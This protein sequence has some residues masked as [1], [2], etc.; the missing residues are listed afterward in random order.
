M[1]DSE[2]GAVTHPGNARQ[3]PPVL[4]IGLVLDALS[5]LFA[6]ALASRI[7]FALGTTVLA[8]TTVGLFQLAR[9]SGG[10]A[11]LAASA[12]GVAT[13]ALAALQLAAA[14]GLLVVTLWLPF[15]ISAAAAAVLVAI[16]ATRV[17]WMS[18][19]VASAVLYIVALF[20]PALA[21]IDRPLL[22]GEP[23]DNLVFGLTCLVYGWMIPQA[24]LANLLLFAAAFLHAYDRPRPAF[25]LALSALVVAVPAPLW[26]GADLRYPHVGYLAWLAS[27]TCMVIAAARAHHARTLATYHDSVERELLESF[28][29]PDRREAA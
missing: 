3:I 29:P 6:S 19:A 15:A 11:R 7:V 10:R 27:I 14:A 1:S 2:L 22:G 26:F 18:F 12:A 4:A 20:L 5:G 28:G 13:G 23:H 17:R 25:W 8:V 16:L 9:R 24:W 21:I